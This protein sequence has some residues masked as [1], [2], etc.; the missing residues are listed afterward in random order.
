MLAVVLLPFSLMPMLN[1]RLVLLAVLPWMLLNTPRTLAQA[2]VPV[3]RVVNQL[4]SQTELPILL[5]D[6]IPEMDAMYVQRHR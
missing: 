1:F 6:A 2:V 5:P 4:R 3:D